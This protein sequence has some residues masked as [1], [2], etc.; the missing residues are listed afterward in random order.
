MPPTKSPNRVPS[1]DAR[2][3]ATIL[4]TACRASP[5]FISRTSPTILL[6]L[7]PFSY[8]WPRHLPRWRHLCYFGYA[9]RSPFPKAP[10]RASFLA[11]EPSFRAG[12][13]EVGISDL[14]KLMLEG[15]ERHIRVPPLDAFL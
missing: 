2:C 9:L 7:T 3:C 15:L 13:E 4:A 5:L 6:F 8:Q 1:L 10:L 12:V 14:R 11:I